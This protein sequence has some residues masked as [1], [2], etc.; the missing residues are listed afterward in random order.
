MGP[1]TIN[2]RTHS[3]PPAS[4]DSDDRIDM[5]RRNFGK[6]PADVRAA[7]DKER[8]NI[9]CAGDFGDTASSPG[10]NLVSTESLVWGFRRKNDGQ[11]LSRSCRWTSR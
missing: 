8:R 5:A 11:T 3:S 9:C 7:D 2:R 1:H 4:G 10:L 6:D